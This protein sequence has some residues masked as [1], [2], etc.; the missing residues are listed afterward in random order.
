MITD[1]DV[2]RLILR[3]NLDLELVRVTGDV[4]SH[5]HESLIPPSLSPPP[6]LVPPSSF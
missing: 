3:R 2:K 4:M 1:T 5:V 6:P